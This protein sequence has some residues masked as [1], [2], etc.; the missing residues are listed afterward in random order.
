MPQKSSP[1]IEANFGWN[2]GESNWNTGMD[3]NLLK[4]SFLLDGNV[5]AI[6]NS[7]PAAV[8]GKSYFLTSDSRVYY[9]VDGTYYS[10]PVPK[11]FS[12]KI[13]DT[14][15]EKIFNGTSLI[16]RP[17]NDDLRAQVNNL[18][19]SVSAI[20]SGLNSTNAD[21]SGITTRVNSI[22]Q[23]V[24]D[25]LANN[26]NQDV[27]DL[28]NRMDGVESG[29]SDLQSR[30]GALE[31][32]TG[33]GGDFT[34]LKNDVAQ[35]KTDVSNIQNTITALNSSKANLASPNFTGVPTVPTAT[36]NLEN[37]QIANTA[38]VANAIN[39]KSIRVVDNIDQLKALDTSRFTK[40][41]VLGYYTAG[42][43]GGGTYVYDSSLSSTNNTG[44]I[45]NGWKLNQSGP[46]SVKQ[47]GAR[48]D[49]STV[50]TTA[51]QNAINAASF[52]HIPK[53]RF[54]TGPLSISN[55]TFITGAGST[56]SGAVI[57]CNSTTSNLFNITSSGV[58]IDNIYVDCSLGQK[59]AG[60][61]FSIGGFGRVFLY[62]VEMWNAYNGVVITASTN[63][64]LSSCRA[65][66]VKGSV[67]SVEGGFNHAILDLHSDN[68]SN[69]QP[70]AGIRVTAV[71]DLT[72]TGAKML[73][74]GTALLVD[75]A[76]GSYV[77]S[78]II[79]QSFFDTSN[80]CGR[81][82]SSST[83]QIQRVDISDTWFGSSSA[84]GL[85][86]SNSGSGKVD[87]ICLNNVRCVLC[88]GDGLEIGSNVKNVRVLGGQFSQNTG[89]GISVAS[90]G[91]L[92]MTNGLLGAGDGF[93][94]NRYGAYL[95]SGALGRIDSARIT[96][97][98]T[99][100]VVNAA[101]TAFKIQ[102]TVGYV[103]DNYGTWTATTSSTGEVTIP[104]GLSGTPSYVGVSIVEF[105]AGE[106]NVSSIDSTNMVVRL[107]N[108][109]DNS[110]IAN[111]SKTVRWIAK[112]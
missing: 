107:R 94:G 100:A 10:S 63:V 80:L 82:R 69:S 89:S 57:L 9:A 95:N 111:V 33:T 104:H 55:E 76:A 19:N 27:T 51:L 48:G 102:D 13:K 8:N 24:N 32:Q 60:N 11:W 90:G 108:S 78:L 47:F 83:G 25:I 71:G 41:F 18:S 110:A 81:I 22:Q 67:V 77:N 50:D 35:L 66:S 93:N 61:Y 56:S 98:T 101:G 59:T 75:V 31:A 109:N 65:F 103:T 26:N 34:Q 16:D 88:Q 28:Q 1:F 29:V 79:N 86:I 7:L 53:G 72:I 58:Q 62:R 49:G 5:D 73:Q 74:C 15:V 20:Q 36:A 17:S 46:V 21:V 37:T 42:D 70:I 105:S 96:G 6:V 12:I 30:V 92:F 99:G 68:P 45:I 85:V 97:N 3:E 14:G 87:G 2:Y 4:F 64:T 54:L 43:G 84:Q 112:L 106:A 23:Q 39:S 44:T 52:L 91:E 40:A 38:F